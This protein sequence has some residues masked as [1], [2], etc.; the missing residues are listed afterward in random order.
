[1]ALRQ[2]GHQ[3]VAG[4]QLGQDLAARSPQ[5][6]GQPDPGEGLVFN[7][8]HSEHVKPSPEDSAPWEAPASRSQG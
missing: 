4:L 6:A 3:R 1:M 5:Q 2:P 8:D 7:Q